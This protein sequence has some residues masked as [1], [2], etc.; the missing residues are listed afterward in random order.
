MTQ[1]SHAAILAQAR[2]AFASRGLLRCSLRVSLGERLYSVR[3]DEECFSVYRVNDKPFLPPGLPGWMVCRLS[4][5]ECFSLDQDE[6]ACALP[7]TPEQLAQARA[8][9]ELVLE[10]LPAEDA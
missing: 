5:Q 9:L 3:C 4:A 7:Q 8:W 2:E 6:K 10:H 1:D